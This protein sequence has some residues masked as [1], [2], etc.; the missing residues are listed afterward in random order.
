[1]QSSQIGT[2]GSSGRESRSS[3]SKPRRLI[4]PIT[5]ERG[6][7][8]TAPKSVN[9]PKVART[10]RHK[11]KSRRWLKYIVRSFA[12]VT[13]LVLCAAGL[14]AYWGY[15]RA[16]T[17]EATY[18]QVTTDVQGIQSLK[19]TNFSSFT[20]AD[21]DRVHSQFVQLQSDLNLLDAETTVPARLQP[22][23]LKLPYLGPRYTAGRQVLQIA[24]IL[25]GSGVQAAAIGQQALKAYK[26]TGLSSSVAPSSPTWLDVINQ[27]MPQIVQI[28]NQIDEALQLRKQVDETV[29][30]ASAQAKLSKL[31]QLASSHDLNKLIDTQLPALQAAFGG[32]GPAR[33]LILIQNPSE[34]RPSGG[35]PGTIALVTFDRGQLRSYDFYDVYD[36]NLAYT[37]TPHQWVTQPWPLSKYAP[38]PQLSILDASWW[39]NFPTS[40][41]TIMKMYRTSG[42]PPIKGVVAIDPAMVSAMLELTGPMT[43]NVDGEMRTITAANVHDEIERQRRLAR[44]GKKTVD[45]HKQVVAII[46]KQLIDQFKNGDRSTVLEMVNAIKQTADRRDLQIYSSDPAVQTLIEQRHWGG[47][48]VPDASKPTIAVTYANVAFG[49]SSEL[50][51]PSYTLTLGPVEAGMRSAHL[52]ISM[53]HTGSPT[54]DPFYEGFQRWWMDV[55][56]PKGSI[57]TGSSIAD[58]PNP[59]EPNGGSYE[60][61]LMPASSTSMTIDFVVP[62][63][64]TIVFR[65][66]P[67][68]HNAQVQVV[69][70]SCSVA[71]AP[72]PLSSD[73]TF[74]LN[75]ICKAP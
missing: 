38:S 43:I 26:T 20:L 34:L 54:A 24:Q 68:L 47:R 25:A 4:K 23:V 53:V 69:D 6:A 45:V 56:L 29:L 70:Q 19:S 30:P 48:L 62:A 41:A 60:I 18:H 28:K 13:V 40:A 7:V 57:R 61:P 14:A 49:K 51:D 2:A 59:E 35:F 17:V 66:Q 50:M 33:Y 42:W 74:N 65:R 73:L 32:D 22:W 1:M 27:N 63:S 21:A 15:Q 8:V 75:D 39:S 3:A 64:D 55:T 31:D 16:K 46:G 5:V 12:V 71:T 36:L 37:T 72:Q 52:T 10:R 9:V 11:T 58:V 44:A 67:G